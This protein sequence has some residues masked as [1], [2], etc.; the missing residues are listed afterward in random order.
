V[1]PD[2]GHAGVL[3]ERLERSLSKVVPIEG[4]T[5]LGGKDEAVILP[6]PCACHTHFEL[7]PALALKAF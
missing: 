2:F 4:R 7:P 5:H 6:E 1:K 3:Q